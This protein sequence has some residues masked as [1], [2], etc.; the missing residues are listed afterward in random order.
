MKN[1]TDRARLETR[2]PHAVMES[3]KMIKQKESNTE[4]MSSL[5]FLFF[6]VYSSTHFHLILWN[7]LSVL[8]ITRSV[9]FQATFRKTCSSQI[10]FMN[11]DEIIP[12]GEVFEV[13]GEIF[14]KQLG[15]FFETKKVDWVS[16]EFLLSL[17]TYFYTLLRDIS[18]LRGFHTW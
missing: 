8:S 2:Q 15:S 4:M 14:K 6:L 12:C 11:P 13:E 10:N 17:K 9:K 5:L 3:L 16:V 7:E 1:D 18:V